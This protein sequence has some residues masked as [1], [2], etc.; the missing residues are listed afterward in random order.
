MHVQINIFH[1]QETNIVFFSVNEMWKLIVDDNKL[2]YSW[3]GGLAMVFRA[4]NISK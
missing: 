1:L 3:N 2:N 4:M